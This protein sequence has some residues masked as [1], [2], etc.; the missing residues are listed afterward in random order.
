MSSKKG[1]SSHPKR[2]LIGSATFRWA[3]LETIYDSNPAISEKFSSGSYGENVWHLKF[4]S[5]TIFGAQ[6]NQNQFV[7]ELFLDNSRLPEVEVEL[8]I[9]L[10]SY[11]KEFSIVKNH[12]SVKKGKSITLLSLTN[13]DKIEKAYKISNNKF[14][15]KLHCR[16]SHYSTNNTHL[17]TFLCDSNDIQVCEHKMLKDLGVIMKN[18]KLSDVDLIVKRQRFHAHKIILASRSPVFMAMFEN[19][20]QEKLSNM[21]DIPDINPV[22]MTKLLSYIY[23]DQVENIEDSVEDLIAAAEKYQLEGL[24][25][26]CSKVILKKLDEQNVIGYL[27]LA[28][29]YNALYLKDQSLNFICHHIKNLQKMNGLDVLTSSHPKLLREILV[30]ISNTTAG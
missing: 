8:E 5:R 30:K 19:D 27:I 11:T 18:N 12:Y 21:I 13:R 1:K 9:S 6:S 28:D 10:T 16:I 25:C 22:T 14:A 26:I 4:S 7:L 29:R 15:A 20:M 23:T 17:N 2:D 3:I 24:K